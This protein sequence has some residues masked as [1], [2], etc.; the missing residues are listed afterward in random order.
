MEQ[1]IGSFGTG[2]TASGIDTLYDRSF[3]G[4]PG[5]ISR[6]E[7]RFQAALRWHST[8]SRLL[9]PSS[10]SPYGFLT[11]WVCRAAGGTVEEQAGPS[12]GGS[13]SAYREGPAQSSKKT[14]VNVYSSKQLKAAAPAP[15][16]AHMGMT[17]D[18]ANRDLNDYFGSIDKL[19]KLQERKEATATLSRLGGET[20]GVSEGPSTASVVAPRRQ[21]RGST[22]ARAA[23]VRRRQGSLY[24]L[25]KKAVQSEEFQRDLV[26][27]AEAKYKTSLM[28]DF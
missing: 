3:G 27:D 24:S 21:S 9:T 25:L 11:V 12:R 22:Q 4:D 26:D 28:G 6:G 1:E 18:E 2:Y 19:V 23:H 14:V 5:H 7:L 15:A 8:L 20:S 16:P 17:T 10:S 13:W